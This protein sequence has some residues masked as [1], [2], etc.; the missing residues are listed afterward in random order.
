MNANTIITT[1]HVS[2][3]NDHNI[4]QLT[5][6]ILLLCVER[7]SYRAYFYFHWF[8]IAATV[9]LTFALVD[10]LFRLG[11]RG[12]DALQ[13]VGSKVLRWVLLFMFLSACGLMFTLP[14]LRDSLNLGELILLA[15]RCAR[16]MLC[17]SSLLLIIGS[18]L[19]RISSRSMLFGIALGVSSLRPRKSLWTPLFSR[20]L[21]LRLSVAGSTPAPI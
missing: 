6:D 3:T 10:E 2:V 20:A 14:S 11:F 16:I 18:P 9:L 1:Q 8:V 17:L 21:V 15:D 12:Y 13:S 19:V 4:L 5:T 7:V